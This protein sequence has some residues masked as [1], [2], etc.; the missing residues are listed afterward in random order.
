[1]TLELPLRQIS[2]WKCVFEAKC[3]FWWNKQPIWH[4]GQ[5]S[6]ENG[7][8]W[9]K[10]ENPCFENFSGVSGSRFCL[11]GGEDSQG[12]MVV[13]HSK[14]KNGFFTMPSLDLKISGTIFSFPIRWAETKIFEIEDFRLEVE[15]S[16]SVDPK[17]SKWVFAHLF[18]LPH[19]THRNWWNRI[20]MSITHF[21]SFRRSTNC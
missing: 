8:F 9:L 21:M 14:Y 17:I 19:R 12:F 16:Q 7:I 10:K 20:W 18:L 2:G 13:K 3:G 11:G 6:R 1:M 15:R 4:L 5:V